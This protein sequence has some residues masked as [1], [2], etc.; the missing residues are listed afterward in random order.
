M[1]FTLQNI[2]RC[3]LRQDFCDENDHNGVVH[4]CIHAVIHLIEDHAKKAE[5]PVRFAATKVIEGDSLIL[6]KLELGSE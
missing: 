2:R 4:R 6:E 1:Q 5:I 3:P